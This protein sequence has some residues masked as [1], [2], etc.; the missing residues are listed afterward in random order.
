MVIL[1]LAQ[2]TDDGELGAGASIAKWCRQGNEVHYIAF[3]A[4]ESVQEEEPFDV[5]R[6]ECQRATRSLGIPRGHTQILAFEVRQFARD[7]QQI[8]DAMVCPEPGG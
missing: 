2:H 8:L 1:V 3:S 5:L 6:E 7:R 4:C